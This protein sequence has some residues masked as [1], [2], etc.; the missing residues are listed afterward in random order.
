[1]NAQDQGG[2][3]VVGA[4][5]ALSQL[6]FGSNVK[7]V[8]CR[9]VWRHS[10]C[11]SGA[12]ISVHDNIT[13]NVSAHGV[14][15]MRLTPT[16]S[17]LGLAVARNHEISL[18]DAVVAA[19]AAATAAASFKSGLQDHS[20][21]YRGESANARSPVITSAMA[22]PTVPDDVV[23]PLPLMG[24]VGWPMRGYDGSHSGR[25]PFIG[26]QT[27]P[28]LKWQQVFGNTS[29][30][31]ESSSAVD[32]FGRVFVGS[33]SSLWALNLSTGGVLWQHDLVN[34]Q[35]HSTSEFFSSPAVVN[36]RVLAGSGSGTLFVFDA[37]TGTVLWTFQTGT[38]VR[39]SYGGTGLAPITSS[40]VVSRDGTSAFVG[41]W[42][43]CIYAFDPLR[44]IIHWTYQAMDSDTNTRAQ[45]RATPALSKD[46]STLYFPAGRSLYAASCHSI[47]M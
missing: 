12:V 17:D 22:S 9:D 8:A 47:S 38:V 3:D 36:D 28:T 34:Q 26:P 41:A 23:L 19:H 21:E 35:N 14:V 11:A 46:D 45:I 20:S 2:H 7:S 13:V 31:T 6:G 1:M 40:V 27:C 16:N 25:A 5:V 42:D 18:N 43:G 29:S 37:Q 30:W 39:G 24:S 4:T 15:M 10:P 33:G 32:P 44:G